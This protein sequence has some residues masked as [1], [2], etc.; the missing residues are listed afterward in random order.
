MAGKTLSVASLGFR[1]WL[2]KQ[3][4]PKLYG[5]W[6]ILTGND[7]EGLE[8]PMISFLKKHFNGKALVGC[9]VGVRDG[10]NSK[11]ILS[12]LNVKK[13]FLVDPY[14]PYF[15]PLFLQSN[16]VEYQNVMRKRAF[17]S[18]AGFSDRIV[19]LI[20]TSDNALKSFDASL[21][22]CYIDGDHCYEQVKLDIENYGNLIK[23]GGVLGG[24]DFS[25]S[26]FGVCRAV[27]EAWQSGKWR[28]FGGGGLDWWMIK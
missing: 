16:T 3:L 12:T 9:E 28:V 6:C 8:R 19:W 27:L 11:R 2:I 1:R 24:H 26:Y 21:D 25:P 18:L 22:F 23:K 17:D 13:L 10:L 5:D 15:E 20:E 7:Y 14:M 4:S